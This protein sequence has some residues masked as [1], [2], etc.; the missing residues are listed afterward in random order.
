MIQWMGQN[1][2]D[3][4]FIL[5][6][7]ADFAFDHVAYLHLWLFQLSAK[8]DTAKYEIWDTKNP[9]LQLQSIE[10]WGA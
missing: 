8:F 5:T 2:G 6:S 10:T 1:S 4:G 7:T 3:M 9:Q